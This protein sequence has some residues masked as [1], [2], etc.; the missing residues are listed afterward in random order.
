MDIRKFFKL[1]PATCF[2]V[3]MVY[4]I[5]CCCHGFDMSDE[6][7]LMTLYRDFSEGER[8][9]T[10]AGGYPLTCW[11]GGKLL[12]ILP[13]GLLVFRLAGV[14]IFM[15][16]GVV[17][18]VFLS[19]R[20][21]GIVVSVGLLTLSFIFAC[22]PKP[23]GYNSLTAVFAV[24]SVIFIVRGLVNDQAVYL[25]F[26]GCILGL[27]V[28]VRLPN[29]ALV[30][31]AS[32]PFFAL[33]SFT[34]KAIFR[35]IRRSALILLGFFAGT[36]IGI[37]FL[38]M[39]GCWGIVVDFVQSIGELAGGDSSHGHLAM[40]THI[41]YNYVNAGIVLLF[42][43]AMV[44]LCALGLTMSPFALILIII[45]IEAIFLK[46]FVDAD[47][48]LGKDMLSLVNALA[49]VGA[50]R[51][52]FCNVERRIVAGASIILAVLMPL[53]SDLGFVTFWCG[54]ILAYPIGL[55]GLLD[56]MSNVI[57]PIKYNRKGFCVRRQAWVVAITLC[58]MAFCVSVMVKGWRRAYYDPGSRHRKTC[59]IKSFRAAGI[60]TRS[61]YAR[62]INPLFSELRWYVKTG[63]KVLAYDWSPM[64]YYLLGL[65]AYGGVAW[66]CVLY[67]EPY[68]RA[69]EEERSRNAELPVVVLQHYRAI[70]PCVSSC[71]YDESRA[72][73]ESHRKM[74][75]TINAFVL[76][77]H[78]RKVW[79]N[80]WYDIY[81]P[82]GRDRF[83]TPCLD[84]WDKD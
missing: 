5:Y 32:L 23:F 17:V 50:V 72:E 38:Q 62:R 68:V 57:L 39:I 70:D 66:P 30:G 31:L 8:N 35:E 79:S 54:P 33:E 19:K 51:Y 13:D 71:Y 60:K 80:E 27:N 61:R 6:G 2:L 44:M 4:W 67:G 37:V 65:R 56:S 29:L 43:C 53:G 24:I 7:F 18:Y 21:S 46:N 73:N 14:A 78:Y 10:S 42:F 16:M 74:I 47:T 55:C 83:E 84:W 82:P 34:H 48:F 81:L 11:I 28:F 20:F 40:L 25:F 41:V 49:L 77:N 63:D 64:L 12:S 1:I 58:I 52:F 26:G 75:S 22:D 76:Q 3:A 69:I 9:I 59:V 36:A 15:A 45:G